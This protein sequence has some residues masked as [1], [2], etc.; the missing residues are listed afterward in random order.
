MGPPIRNRQ[1]LGL[2]G[3][4]PTPSAVPAGIVG[5]LGEC[6]DLDRAATGAAEDDHIEIGTTVTAEAA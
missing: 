2:W 1:L 5:G 3:R 6:V 4:T